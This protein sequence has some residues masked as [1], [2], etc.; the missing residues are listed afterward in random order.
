MSTLL[1]V[2]CASGL[3]AAAAKAAAGSFDRVVLADIQR[4]PLTDLTKEITAAGAMCHSFEVDI[5][6]MSS[7]DRMFDDMR[8][9]GIVID[10]AFN[11]AGVLGEVASLAQSDPAQWRACIEVNLCGIYHLMKAEIAEFSRRKVAGRILNMSSEYGL[12]GTDSVSAYVASKHGVIGLTK[13]AAIETAPDGVL[14]NALCPG[15]IDSGM[16]RRYADTVDGYRE[17]TVATIPMRRL[18]EAQEVCDLAFWLLGP[19]NSYVTGQAIP[20]DGGATA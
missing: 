19:R 17:H 7:V 16:T 1:I 4:D 13:A 12:R 10:A 15:A 3:G 5:R 18:G 6:D 14:I 11:N 20:I 9:Q 8:G 2:G